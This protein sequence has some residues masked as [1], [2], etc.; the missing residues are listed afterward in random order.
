MSSHASHL[1][2]KVIIGRIG[3]TFGVHGWLH[4]HSFCEPPENITQYPQWQLGKQ[5]RWHT[6]TVTDCKP[7]QNGYIAKFEHIDSPEEA[8]TWVNADI[9]IEASQLPDLGN[10]EYYQKDLIGLTAKT[11]QGRILG[12]VVEILET[13][14]NDV[15]V[16][17]GNGRH[18]I[19]YIDSAII[20]I[21][22]AERLIVVEWELTND[23]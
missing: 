9:A 3:K 23:T 19:P 13:G 2:Q 22:L 21:D 4:I 16:I 20:R 12:N 11:T 10:N 6:R 1:P 7:H 17:E 14:A 5:H 18:L 15:F 8:K